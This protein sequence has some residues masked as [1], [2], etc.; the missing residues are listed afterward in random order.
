MAWFVATSKFLNIHL[1][2]VEK[3]KYYVPIFFFLT[4]VHQHQFALP[5]CLL[6]LDTSLHIMYYF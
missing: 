6:R 3:V 4:N 2:Y 1:P 5:N